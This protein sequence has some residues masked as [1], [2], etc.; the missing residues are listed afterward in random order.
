MAPN[1]VVGVTASD[2]EIVPGTALGF[3]AKPQDR[4]TSALVSVSAGVAFG[5]LLPHY[6]FVCEIDPLAALL[7]FVALHRYRTGFGI[8]CV[9]AAIWKGCFAR[10]LP[11]WV[12]GIYHSRPLRSRR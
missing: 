8:R 7:T 5:F 11:W 9:C 3:R 10:I 6:R 12:D 2:V 1:G 4:V